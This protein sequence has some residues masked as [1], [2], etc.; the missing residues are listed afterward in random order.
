MKAV[1]LDSLSLG[2]DVDLT[3]LTGDGND[4]TLYPSAGK[5]EVAERIAGADIVVANKAPLDRD[6]LAAADAL[7]LICVPATGVNNVDLQAA[8]EAGIAVCNCTA[9]GT[10]A[11]SQ[12]VF[13]LMLSLATK[14][15]QYSAAVA[16]GDWARSKAFCLMDYPIMELQGKT[17]GI[18]GYGELGRAVAGLAKAFGMQVLISERPGADSV[19]EGRLLLQDMLPRCDVLSLHLPLNE[20]SRNLIG[21]AELQLLPDH[22]LLINCARGGIV[23]ETALAAALRDGVIGGAGVDVL[24]EEP[25]RNGNPLLSD[26]IPNLIVTPHSAWAS[27]E[28]RQRIVQIVAGH[29]SHFCKGG[30]PDAINLKGSA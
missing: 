16:R 17:L 28:A 11:V 5:D 25:P 4:W 22:A 7:K 20:H 14:L 26:D 27:R 9:Y 21:A 3:P 15:P 13:A 8:D 24:S 6:V 29:I 18:V 1:F 12:H 2:D 19:R 10:A 30:T 23:D